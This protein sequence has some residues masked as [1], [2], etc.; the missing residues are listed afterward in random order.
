M[1]EL[2]KHITGLLA[3]YLFSR[4]SVKLKSLSVVL[5]HTF[6]SLYA[7]TLAHSEALSEPA[8][9]FELQDNKNNEFF[10]RL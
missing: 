1:Q 7:E 10:L 8:F 3:L 9:S 4:S 6:S 2:S 5:V